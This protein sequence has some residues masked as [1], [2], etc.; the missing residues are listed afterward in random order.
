MVLAGNEHAAR[1]DFHHRMIRAMVAELHLQG[2]GAA[3]Q[4]QQLV[5]QTNSKDRD[6][7]LQ[8]TRYRL[9]GVVAGLRIPG[10]IT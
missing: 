6:I 2:L 7:R 5:P 10:T 3:R 8:E 4:P 1:I 9:Y